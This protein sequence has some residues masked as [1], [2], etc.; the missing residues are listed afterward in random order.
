M[1]VDALVALEMVWRMVLAAVCGIV[2]GYERMNHFKAAG[3]KTHMIVGLS[4]AIMTIVSIAGFPNSPDEGSARV[5]A[6]IISG[7]GF[8]G[9][10]II[11]RRHNSVQGLTTAAGVWGTAGI[12]MAVGCGLYAVGIAG[13]IVFVGLRSIVQNAEMFKNGVQETYVIKMDADAAPTRPLDLAGD[14]QVISYAIK[15]D[16]RG[17]LELEATLLFPDAGIERAW[18]EEVSSRAGVVQFKRF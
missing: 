17:D 5:A 6:Q 10:G 9:A 2:I 13:T 18:I 14:A 12:G 4:A 15:R 7:M 11:F 8:L 1:D 3:V 16:A